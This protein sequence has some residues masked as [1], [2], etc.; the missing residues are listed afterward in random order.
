MPK[1]SIG[2]VQHSAVNL[3]IKGITH[4]V[5]K[6]LPEAI[7]FMSITTMNGRVIELISYTF[8]GQAV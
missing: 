5:T 3:E 4:K 6:S 1:I 7:I 2:L 8:L